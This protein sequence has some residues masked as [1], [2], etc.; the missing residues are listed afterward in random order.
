MYIDIIRHG[1]RIIIETYNCAAL[2]STKARRAILR[3]SRSRNDA[4]LV[5][6]KR[7]PG[8]LSRLTLCSSID[9]F[10]WNLFVTTEVRT[11][12]Y[13]FLI[14]C[15]HL[16]LNFGQ[17]LHTDM[18]AQPA[19]HSASKILKVWHEELWLEMVKSLQIELIWLLA[20]GLTNVSIAE[21]NIKNIP[22][23]NLHSPTSTTPS[24]SSP[25]ARSRMWSTSWFMWLLRHGRNIITWCIGI[26]TFESIATITFFAI[27]SAPET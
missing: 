5:N 10:W 19:H 15:L 21:I 18:A 11:L 26:K 4:C 16:R 9:L 25:K 17:V 14:D 7:W 23:A 27:H 22:T 12:S 1:G 3:P 8:L 13:Y 20:T 6:L 2:T 24:E